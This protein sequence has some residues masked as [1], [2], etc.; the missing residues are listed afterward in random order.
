M[1]FLIWQTLIF[2]M[3][4]TIHFSARS[5]LTAT[6]GS[7]SMSTAVER[8]GFSFI[9]LM[10]EKNRKIKSE[11][12]NFKFKSRADPLKIFKYESLTNRVWESWMLISSS[13]FHNTNRFPPLRLKNSTV[14]IETDLNDFR[15]NKANCV[16]GDSK[17]PFEDN[18]LFYFNLGNCKLVYSSTPTDVNM[19]GMFDLTNDITGMS[20]DEDFTSE[21]LLYC[22]LLTDREGKQWKL[23]NNKEDDINAVLCLT[24]KCNN[25]EKKYDFCLEYDSDQQIVEV[26]KVTK[27]SIILVPLP[28]PSCN[29]KWD[30]KQLGD[31]W[32]CT[33]K[34]GNEQSPIDLPIQ[35]NSIL[36]E[37]RPFFNY[38]M[39][40]YITKPSID[41]S[42]SNRLEI[43]NSGNYLHIL[44]NDMGRLT[45]ED[46]T[47]FQAQEI[48]FHTPSNHKI[49]GKQYDLEVV[50]IHSGITKG[51][52]GKQASLSFLFESAPGIYNKF[53]DDMDFFNLPNPYSK[54]SDLTNGLYI[55]K[56]LYDST[57]SGTEFKPISFYTYQG[58]LMTPPCTENTIV[59]VAADPLKL[60]ATVIN[61]LKEALRKPDLISNT[62]KIYASQSI[63]FSNRK[64]QS[65]NGRPVFF[66]Q[67][68]DE[69][70]KQENRQD[71][72]Y[73]KVVDKAYQ[74]FYVS[75][76][77]PSG[78][79]GSFVV[80]EKEA[81]K[82]E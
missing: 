14:E 7:K 67:G 65:N 51:D 9:G 70:L 57:Q 31:D 13:E 68:C 5:T 38:N 56:L 77:A 8:P 44:H 4:I 15:I 64:I 60:S 55:P 47:V 23:C 21:E 50:I 59:Y 54:F 10:K 11:Y 36:S 75:N 48:M 33:C 72:H 78:I 2:C 32:E 40:P 82:S 81:T 18:R 42:L 30:Y 3:Q 25:I 71:G 69:E 22:L 45:T 79:P 19:L 39:L 58:S 35:T 28:S 66:Y 62:G 52:I 63:N 24:A 41:G 29:S 80:T 61:L 6:L 37:I 34:E 16:L 12:E 27:Q 43:R 73:E 49:N 53:F 20:K 1:K 74:Y 17:R 46:G 76:S 26:K